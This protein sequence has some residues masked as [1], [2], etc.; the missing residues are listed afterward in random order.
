MHATHATFA[1]HAARAACGARRAVLLAASVA[2]LLTAAGPGVALGEEDG[3]DT[4]TPV[5]PP[6]VSI[7]VDTDAA[8]GGSTST[9]IVPANPQSQNI[10][11]AIVTV[12][13]GGVAL[14]EV[15]LCLY[16]VG[17]GALAG[18]AVADPV[19]DAGS[20]P[21]PRTHLVM[22]WR[23]DR[24]VAA[25]GGDPGDTGFRILGSNLHLD[26]DSSSTYLDI[27]PADR[28]KAGQALTLTFRVRTSVALLAADGEDGGWAL[29][30][31]AVDTEGNDSTG[32]PE[33]NW[34]QSGITVEPFFAAT[35]ARTPIGFGALIPGQSSLVEG[36]R[37]GVFRSNAA[38][39][40]LI[41]G[42]DFV[43]D[44]GTGTSVLTLKEDGG[45]A[46][47]GQ[48]TLECSDGTTLGGSPLRITKT[49]QP[50]V[51]GLHPQGTGE[52]EDDRS[53]SCR[54][55]YGGGATGVGLQHSGTIGITI[56]ADEV[57]GAE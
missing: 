3:P 37:S 12:V 54:M 16:L 17:D 55:A 45:E 31:V 43:A 26:A 29:R 5:D 46:G 2:L 51:D 22:T 44:T 20:D 21:D 15:R 49:A 42:S 30:V 35:T 8:D 13:L 52:A 7:V 56:E 47:A 14:D 41:S 34:E 57:G 23:P 53:Y 38:A 4:V 19:P 1:T 33:A 48:I 39:Q 10:T 32:G 36:V 40:L 24:V 11:Q 27:D 28:A 9:T 6:S 18:C 25:D 50:L